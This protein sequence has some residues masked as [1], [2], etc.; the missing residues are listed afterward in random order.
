MTAT[1]NNGPART[2]NR[3]EYSDRLLKG[4][5]RRSYQPMVDLDWDAPLDPDKYYLPPKVVSLY[6]TEVWNRMSRAEQ[7]E[8]SRHEMVNLLSTGIWFENMLNQGLLRVM[9]HANPV[10]SETLYSLAEIGDE[11][12]HMTMFA[13]AIEKTGLPPYRMPWYQRVMANLL[14]LALKGPVLWV[15]ALIGEEI[16][17]ALQREIMDD[18]ELQPLVQRL[19]RIHVTEEARHIQF[20][21]DGIRQRLDRTPTR[22]KVILRL[23]NGL[24]GPIFRY[25]L[26]NKKMYE[27]VELPGRETMRL[28]RSNPAFQEASQ[29]GFAPLYKFL[30]ET[31]LMGRLSRRMWRRAGFVA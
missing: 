16:F 31:G 14:P 26:T 18:P 6:G 30:E 19:M 20:A 13:K 22:V 17:D 15:A 5:V 28:A 23:T 12:R 21:R 10:S 24:G 8:L 9:M 27:A 1:L 7:I 25:L 2:P 4:T 3:E 29:T 11:T